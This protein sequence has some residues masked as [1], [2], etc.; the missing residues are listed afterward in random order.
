MPEKPRE[1]DA[2][3]WY[4]FKSKEFA[5]G[6]VFPTKTEDVFDDEAKDVKIFQASTRKANYSVIVKPIP[7]LLTQNS[8]NNLYIDI[9]EQMFSSETTRVITERNVRVGNMSGKEI[10]F[11][12]DDQKVFSRLYIN[13]SKLYIVSVILDKKDYATSFDK[14]FLKFLDSFDLQI[15]EKNVG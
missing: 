3:V 11:E 2:N 8:K 13:E 4:E 14:W 10:F 7:S 12:K 1:E 9:F 6:I 15:K 5:F